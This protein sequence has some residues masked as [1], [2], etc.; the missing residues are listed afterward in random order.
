MLTAMVTI[1]GGVA[2]AESDPET[3]IIERE[4]EALTRWGQGDPLGYIEVASEG[5]TY[6]DPSLEK[7]LDGKAAYEELL[8]PIVGKIQ[9]HR[10]EMLN[11]KVQLS[12]D[13]G[14]LS[15]NLLNYNENDSVT[16]RWNSTE[17]YR[18]ED[19]EWMLLHSH[20][21]LTKPDRE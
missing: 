14:I 10:F 13:I 20:W 7:R 15:F 4:R 5:I 6:F 12:G 17:V 1:L 18:K 21:S 3:A 11:T 8:T 19:G 16:N 2:V 9:I